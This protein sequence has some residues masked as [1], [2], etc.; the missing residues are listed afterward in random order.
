[1][2]EPHKICPVCGK[3]FIRF[4]TYF[5]GYTKIGT[6]KKVYYHTTGEKAKACVLKQ[7]YPR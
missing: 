2:N 6:N 3:Y 7:E 5:T 4:K 1:M